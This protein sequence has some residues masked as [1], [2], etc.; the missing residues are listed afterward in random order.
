MSKVWNADIPVTEVDDVALTFTAEITDPN[1]IIM[2][3]PWL[4]DRITIT[5]HLQEDA[6]MPVIEGSTLLLRTKVA[7][8]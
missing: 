3:A 8:S 1:I 4:V 6:E 7:G 5:Y 2:T